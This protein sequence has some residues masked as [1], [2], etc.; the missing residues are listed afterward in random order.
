MRSRTEATAPDA[1]RVV[2]EWAA[3]AVAVIAL[4]LAWW[5]T[6]HTL[7]WQSL[8]DAAATDG[9]VTLQ[10]AAGTLDIRTIS[11]AASNPATRA[12]HMQLLA[13]PDAQRR[14]LLH[15]TALSGLP[16]SWRAENDRVP[17]LALAVSALAD[18]IGGS[19]VRAVAQSGT[20]L[21]L[22]DSVGWLDSATAV[23]RGAQWNVPGPA[24]AFQV[25]GAAHAAA[26]PLRLGR[27]RLF[28]APGWEARYAMQALEEA[29]WRVDADFEIAPR[30]SV[31]AGAPASLDT[32]RYSAVIALD[33]TAWPSG[34][35]IARFV[36][37]G[38]GLVMFG[39]AASG[40][41]MAALRAGTHAQ[42]SPGIPGALR[43]ATPREGLALRPVSSL[44]SAAVVLERSERPGSPIS[45]VARRVGAGRVLQVGWDQSWEWR[46]LGGDDAV[47]AHRDWWR[48]L[49]Q[50]VAYAPDVRVDS[51]IE[52]WQ[53]LPGNAA[54]TADLVARLGP[55]REPAEL[56]ASAAP[57]TP[58]SP[59]WFV[60]A[61]AALLAEWWS[62]R[63][64]G[65][66]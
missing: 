19:V 11:S 42:L 60:L 47:E 5:S 26:A 63:L 62:R 53:P 29:G 8:G 45:M 32:A 64:R 12:L 30:V 10:E 16:V 37:D 21:S 52:R 34:G 49:L 56:P 46:M 51:L 3:R 48:G 20:A 44:A 59:W 15:A 23:A 41:A 61:S 14:A 22:S 24:R 7:P 17:V 40:G 2:A 1:A 38:G 58:P 36:G 54:P 4:L 39:S 6:S 18:P 55:A 35:A 57:L 31:T 33:S 50:R 43:T 27:I 25:N 66:R 28:A 13:T 65:A 9:V